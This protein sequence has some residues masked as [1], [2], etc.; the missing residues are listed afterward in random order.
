MRRNLKEVIQ[1][2]LLKKVK[3]GIMQNLDYISN[4]K[5]FKESMVQDTAQQKNVNKTKR[6]VLKN[7]LK[8]WTNL[9]LWNKIRSRK[10]K[11]PQ[12]SLWF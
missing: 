6:R 3:I 9:I 4:Q 11:S 2:L 8:I 5:Q 7:K 1:T 10:L 12:T